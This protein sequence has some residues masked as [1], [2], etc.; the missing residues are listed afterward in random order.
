M[1]LFLAVI[2]LVAVVVGVTA[3]AQEGITLKAANIENGIAIAWTPVEDAYYYELYRQCNDGSEEVLISKAQGTSFVDSEVVDGLIYAYRAVV[4]TTDEEYGQES[5]FGFVC[6]LG[7]AQITNYYSKDAGLYLEW[8]PVK[9][10]T[11]YYVMRKPLQGGNWQ[12]VGKCAGDASSYVDATASGDVRYCYAVRA[13]AGPH[14]GVSANQVVL[15]HFA[16][17]DIMGVVSIEEGISLRWKE[18]P[19]AKYYM[20]YRRDSQQSKAWKPYALLDSDYTYYVDKDVKSDVVYAYV[21]R[22]ADSTGQLSPF[23]RMVLMKHIGKPVIRSAESSTNGI[24]LTWTKSNGCQGYIIYRKDFGTKDWTIA[25]FVNNAD[26]LDFV[27]KR[28]I[29]SKAYTYTV[30]AVWNKN[31]SDYDE[32]G[33]DVRFLEAPQS[34]VLDTDTA[35]GNVLT[36]RNN[37]Q[38]SVFFIFRQSSGGKWRVIGKTNQ[39]FFADKTADASQDYNYTVRAYTS[40]IYLSGPAVFVSTRPPIP[41]YDSSV[42]MV[43]VTYDDGPSDSVTNGILDILEQY[44]AKATFF[45]L[46]QNID[47]GSEAMARA[48]KLGCEIGTHTY[49]HIDLPTSSESTIREE[50]E[51]TDSLVKKY[52]GKTTTIARAPGGALDDASAQIVG[53]AFFNWSVDTRDWESRDAASVIEIAQ[54]SVTDGSIILMHDIYDSTLEASEYIIPWLINEGYQ[55]VTVSELIYYK[56]GKAP[57]IGVEYYDGYGN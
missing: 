33:V 21:V 52:T 27:D 29:N 45:V 38:A 40:S 55:L 39:N 23:D 6:R 36:W 17:P 31:L 18:V 35:S 12:V 44:G 54:N 2:V 37:P 14:L 48:S 10:A 57:Q 20:I 24:R 19:S 32:K 7:A 8:K 41:V 50:I 43:A 1:S 13:F 47:Y 26:I 4:V 3:F 51:L 30:R 46:G 5:N 42:K 56:S 11:G 15:S 28:V 25:G 16:C 9:A 53:K 49:S 22:A 34:L